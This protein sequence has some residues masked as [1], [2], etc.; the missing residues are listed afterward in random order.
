MTKRANPHWA[1]HLATNLTHQVPGVMETAMKTHVEE[2][3]KRL[4]YLGHPDHLERKTG[5]LKKSITTI[6][7][8]ETASVGS[9]LVYAPVHEFGSVYTDRFGVIRYI[10]PRPF[11]I[12]AFEAKKNDVLADFKRG[13]HD[14]VQEVAI[15]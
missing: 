2:E 10:P 13:F 9:D 7:D 8:G 15:K 3:A 14:I 5:A 6:V 4:V 11:L 12:P 1:E